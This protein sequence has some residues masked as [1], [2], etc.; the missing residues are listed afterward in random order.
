VGLDEYDR[1]RNFRRTP[2]PRGKNRKRAT[3]RGGASAAPPARQFVVQQHAARRLHW[4]FRLE[5]DGVLKSWA[6]PKGPSLVAGERRMAAQ[7]EDHPLEYAGFEG[8]IPKGEYGG[9]TVVV[10]DRGLWQPI[11]DPQRGLAQGKLD[12]TLAGEKLRGRWHLVR[13]RPRDGDRGRA[14]WLLIKGRDAEARPA[15]A[16]AVVATE[17]ASVLTGREIDAVARE[18]DR[19]WSSRSGERGGRRVAPPGDPSAVPGARRAP[20]PVRAELQLA[21]LVDEPPAGSEWLHEIK[22]DGY[23]LLCRTERGKARLLTRNGL[24][25][26]DRFPGLASAL[27]ALP[28]KTALLDG[29]AVVLDSQ[30]KSSFQALQGAL[31]RERA[32]VDVHLVLFDCLYLDGR[33]VRAAPLLER[34][35]LLRALLARVPGDGLLRFS[36]HVIGRGEEFF[37]AACASGVEGIVSKRVGAPY[38]AGRSR[39]WLKVKCSQRQELVIVGFTEPGGSRVGLGALLLGAHDAKG[40]LRYCGKVGTGF[41]AATLKA[42]R[43]K[44][45]PLERRRPALSDPPRMRG[46]HWVAPQ[47]VAEVS[48]SEWTRDGRIRHPV[49]L[50]LREDKPASDVRLEKPE[51]A[52]DSAPAG[53]PTRASAGPRNV[54]AGVSL[55]NPDRVYFPDLGITKR[56]LAAYYEAVAER[57]LPGLAQRPLSLFRCPQG[58]EGECFYQKHANPSVPEAVARVRVRGDKEPYAMVTDLASLVSLVQIGALEL[59]VWGARA[60][61]LDRPDLVVFDLDPDPAVP[62]ARVVETARALRSYLADLGLVAFARVTGG[63]GVH[64]VVPLVR[65]SGWDEVRDFSKGVALE[66]VRLAPGQ[67]TARMS[68]ARRV[69]KIF[70]DWVRNTPEATAIASYSPRARPGAPVALPLAWEELEA[71][72]APLRESVREVPRRLQDPDPWADFEASRRPLTRAALRQVGVGD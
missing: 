54:V 43:A 72:E 39:A 40:A 1:K 12:F 25:W 65:R 59:H 36:D 52:P 28:A 64:V 50:G 38:R 14:S 56:E 3:A 34:K 51:A 15:T 29:E 5:L 61:R 23:R 60:D 9:G 53:N 68:K 21:T 22:L 62:F 63:K 26:T 19:T 37:S 41:D 13:L 24:D 17:R 58:I 20:L 47:L 67:F 6:I 31:G 33:D 7:T 45:H 35:Q 66:L 57:A 49:F 69:G 18:A 55:S 71:L 4:D 16:G 2:E 42:L 70:I 8:V 44:L 48:F 27:R 32:A 30:G 11:G 10:W 46:V